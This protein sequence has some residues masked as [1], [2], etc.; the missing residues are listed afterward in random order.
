MPNPNSYDPRVTGAWSFTGDSPF[1]PLP[2]SATHY[3]N[4][5]STDNT[6]SESDT[7]SK[8]GN[9]TWPNLVPV[10]W[11]TP[12]MQPTADKSMP[13]RHDRSAPKFDGKPSS[14]SAFLDDIS[15]LAAACE[16]NEKDKIRW[17][18]RYAPG[19]K[20]ELWEM[21]PAYKTEKWEDFEKQLY[22][23]Y[24]GSTGDRKYL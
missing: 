13:S 3:P 23:L 15:Q 1:G 6:S 17:T 11:N 5:N 2:Y 16:L 21:L 10:Q 7:D 20:S 19:E 4:P 14:L 24:P 12:T 9:T 8:Q 18:V 22:A